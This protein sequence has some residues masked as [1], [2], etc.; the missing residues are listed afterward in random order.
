MG[1]ADAIFQNDFG[2]GV[3]TGFFMMRS[4]SRTRAFLQTV[5][6]NLHQFPEEQV[7]FNYLLNNFKTLS[8]IAFNWKMLPKEY[9]TYGEVAIQRPKDGKPFSL[10]DENEDFNI[11]ENIVIHHANWTKCFADKIKILDKVKQ[12]V[13]SK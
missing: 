10:W 3:N 8:K 4:T 7:C 5:K 13:Y 2:G 6:G 11:P 9:W 1:D 12:K